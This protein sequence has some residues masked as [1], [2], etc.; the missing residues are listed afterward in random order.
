MTL[1]GNTGLVCVLSYMTRSLASLNLASFFCLVCRD[2]TNRI[3]NRAVDRSVTLA[4]RDRYSQETYISTTRTSVGLC[5]CVRNSGVRRF[6]SHYVSVLL[7]GNS[8]KNVQQLI[9]P[10]KTMWLRTSCATSRKTKNLY[11]LPT[12]CIYVF[13]V[14]LRTNSHYFPTQHGLFGFYNREGTCLL[15]GTNRSCMYSQ[16]NFFT[17]CLW[18]CLVADG[19][20]HF[21]NAFFLSVS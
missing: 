21:E 17:H 4:L 11:L 10:F 9:N 8:R 6:F 7:N 14:D 5:V 12:Q 15:R 3:F 19:R 20:Y 2:I 13:C 18:F 1:L 16:V